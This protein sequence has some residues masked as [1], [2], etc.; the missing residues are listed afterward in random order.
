MKKIKNILFDLGGVLFPLSIKSTIDEFVK[1]GVDAGTNFFEILN[2]DDID[3]RF[4]TGTCTAEE[5]RQRVNSLFNI[6][7]S[8]QKFDTCWN[9]MITNYPDQ[10]TQ[11]LQALK[12]Q[13]YNLYI[14]SN[15]NEIHVDYVEKLAKWP[16][17]L[18]TKK[19]YSNE[20]HLAKPFRECYEYVLN[21]SKIRPEET[22]YIDDR[23]DNCATG[24]E[25]GFVTINL[26][27]NGDWYK[28]LQKTL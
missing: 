13:G 9:S 1:N 22:L 27:M 6:M 20:I 18:F 8:D 2:G 19:Y 17:N 26:T 24:R 5:F 11:K 15:I 28:E 23:A 10:N 16:E 14:L 21:D 3:R 7:L 25:M 12:N 4:N